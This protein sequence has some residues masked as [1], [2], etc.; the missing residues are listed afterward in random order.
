MA[1]K[2]KSVQYGG[3]TYSVQITQ[4][5]GKMAGGQSL[6][7]WLSDTKDSEGVVVTDERILDALRVILGV[8]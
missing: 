3:E 5:S 6:P 8:A 4:E 1:T 7:E 2:T